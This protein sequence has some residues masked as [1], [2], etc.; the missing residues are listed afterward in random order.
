MIEAKATWADTYLKVGQIYFIDM[1]RILTLVLMSPIGGSS[2][3]DVAIRR[4][5]KLPQVPRIK[6]TENGAMKLQAVPSDLHNKKIQELVEEYNNPLILDVCQIINNAK[7]FGIQLFELKVC[8][9]KSQMRSRHCLI[10]YTL[11]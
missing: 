1:K 5:S 3:V 11:D 8:C 2:H 9:L 10:M 7:G 4:Y 6:D